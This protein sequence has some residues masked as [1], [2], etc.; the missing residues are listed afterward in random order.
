MKADVDELSALPISPFLYPNNGGSTINDGLVYRLPGR[1]SNRGSLGFKSCL[2]AHLLNHVPIPT[3]N[4]YSAVIIFPSLF[5]QVCWS[6]LRLDPNWLFYLLTPDVVS[7]LVRVLE[8]RL[9]VASCPGRRSGSNLQPLG[10]RQS[11]KTDI[12]SG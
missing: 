2:L 3:T 5:G 6:D 10:R 11:E 7:W 1:R 9:V 12:R 4:S 8:S